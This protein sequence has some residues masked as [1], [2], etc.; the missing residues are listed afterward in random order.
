[1]LRVGE[2]VLPRKGTPTDF[3][4]ATYQPRKPAH[5]NNIIWTEKTIYIYMSSIIH[6]RRGYG[7]ES[8]QEEVYG[9]V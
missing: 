7:F 6:E 2:I 3:Q 9:R 8:K 5:T 1:M 4:K